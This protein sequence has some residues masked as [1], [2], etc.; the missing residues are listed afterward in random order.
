MCLIVGR[1]NIC[2]SH[3]YQLNVCSA[4]PAQSRPVLSGRSQGSLPWDS[5]FLGNAH[6]IFIF[7]FWGVQGKY[8]SGEVSK[9]FLTS[10][11]ETG[12]CIFDLIKNGG[13][14]YSGQSPSIS[15]LLLTISMVHSENFP[16]QYHC[17]HNNL[18]ALVWNSRS[19]TIWPQ[20]TFPAIL[21]TT[22]IQDPARLSYSLFPD[23]QPK[24]D[25]CLCTFFNLK[26]SS[27]TV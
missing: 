27:P 19:F 26:L 16:P 23:P 17:L 2:F 21:C 18:N 8:Y 5:P 7:P 11:K 13:Y 22:P 6:R 14:E 9:D 4:H 3:C 20:L 1:W 12:A 24:L 15:F 10:A 25:S